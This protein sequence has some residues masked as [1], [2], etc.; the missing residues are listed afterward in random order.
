MKIGL[1]LGGGAGLGWAH[2]GV[3]TCLRDH[4]IQPQMVA[5]TSIGAIVG[6]CYAAG[7]MKEVEDIA[8]SMT[9]WGMI[10]LGK[11]GFGSGGLIGT[12]KIEK[13][14]IETLG[15]SDI[16]DLPMPFAAVA[17]D[18]LTEER[19]EIASGDLIEAV[20][21][22]AS[23]P[24]IFAPRRYNGHALIDGGMIDPVPCQ[25]VI[26]QGADYVIGVDLQ[27]DY[28]GRIGKMGLL[29]KDPKVRNKALKSKMKVTRASVFLALKRLG[30]ERQKLYPADMLLSPRVG[31]IEIADFTKAEELIH[32][33]YE[34]MAAEIDL[35]KS[36]L[37]A[38]S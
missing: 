4:G 28:V 12:A 25:S 20:L 32:I 8:R 31:H 37:A 7:K 38:K 5:G 33:G 16:S 21:A 14:L 29:D 23:L 36:E 2:I 1:A 9:L 11:A 13:Q 3:I 19:I 17:A 35:L 18:L 15:V 26:E 10:K 6:A 27:G 24:G 30:V 22:S 34:T